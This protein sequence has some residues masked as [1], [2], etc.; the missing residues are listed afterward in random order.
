MKISVK[1]NFEKEGVSQFQLPENRDVAET[2]CG[3]RG[4]AITQVMHYP[5]GQS[6]V[7]TLISLIY[8]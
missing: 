8:R 4:P 5:C 2:N 7:T 3:A 1:N 6:F